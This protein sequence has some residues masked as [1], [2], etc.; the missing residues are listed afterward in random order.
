MHYL[1]AQHNTNMQREHIDMPVLVWF[2]PPRLAY[3]SAL[4]K[5][6][7]R[8]DISRYDAS[9]RPLKPMYRAK[10]TMTGI[11]S[12]ACTACGIAFASFYCFGCGM[13]Y[14]GEG[15]QGRDWL[16]HRGECQRAQ[17]SKLDHDVEQTAK[18]VTGSCT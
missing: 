18:D 7:S 14:C 16:L 13:Q 1:P 4:M 9:G 11:D 2:N 10:P 8:F 15:C 5:N 12:R 3:S 17:A 6:L